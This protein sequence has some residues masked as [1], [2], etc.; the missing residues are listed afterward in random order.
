MTKYRTGQE[1]FQTR[2]KCDTHSATHRTFTGDTNPQAHLRFG[3]TR[4]QCITVAQLRTG[5]SPP[6]L[7]SY[8]HRIGLQTLS[9]VS[10]LR[11]RRRGGTVS[12]SLLS[13][14]RI[15]TYLNQLHQLNWSSTHV[16]LP[17]VYQ[18]CDMPPRPLTRNDREREIIITPECTARQ[19]ES[20]VSG[21]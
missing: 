14:T 7:A 8:L 18:G 10:V 4:S 16:V 20:W 17:G 13:V 3:W 1:E 21:H 15:G 19:I 2:Y 11:R 5:H 12:S 6:L 9:S